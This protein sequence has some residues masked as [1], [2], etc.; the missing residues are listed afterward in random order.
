[1]WEKFTAAFQSFKN[2]LCEIDPKEGENSLVPAH[3]AASAARPL[4]SYGARA[5]AAFGVL[6][7]AVGIFLPRAEALAR[8]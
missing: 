6:P 8:L 2:M 5:V 4:V 7:I 3:G 1:M